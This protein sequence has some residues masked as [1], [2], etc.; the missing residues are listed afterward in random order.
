MV[1]KIASNADFD[2]FIKERIL[3]RKLRDAISFC[4]NHLEIRATSDL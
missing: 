3:S 4:K 1:E 2:L